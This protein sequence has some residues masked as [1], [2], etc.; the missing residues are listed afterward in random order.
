M[1]L[2]EDELIAAILESAREQNAIKGLL[3]ARA[4]DI[5]EH[6]VQLMLLPT[7]PTQPSEYAPAEEENP[8]QKPLPI[9]MLFT[10]PEGLS[11]T[12]FRQLLWGRAGSGKSVLCQYLAW[13]FAQR[14]YP[15]WNE[16][17][18][19]IIPIKLKRLKLS[20]Y[21]TH[22]DADNVLLTTARILY[23]E[24]L[25]ENQ[26]ARLVN[27]TEDSAARINEGVRL[28]RG[29]LAHKNPRIALLLDG[30]DEVMSD[31]HAP[32]LEGAILRALC[33]HPT[34]IITSRPSDNNHALAQLGDFQRIIEN[35]GFN[36]HDVRVYI[37]TFFD[38]NH[39]RQLDKGEYLIRYLIQHTQILELAQIPLLL[40]LFC[41]LWQQTPNKEDLGQLWLQGYTALYQ[42]VITAFLQY[43]N[44]PD[45]VVN[46]MDN[47]LVQSL[48]NTYTLPL[49]FLAE[50]AYHSFIDLK[51][52]VAIEPPILMDVRGRYHPPLQFARDIQPLG[53]LTPLGEDNNPEALPPYEYIHLTFKEYFTAL[54]IAQN[55]ATLDHA[56]NALST[57]KQHL[58]LHRYHTRWEWVWRFLA[59]LLHTPQG[60]GA[61][62]EEQRERAQ[63]RFWSIIWGKPYEDLGFGHLRLLAIVLEETR[64]NHH[65]AEE[66]EEAWVDALLKPQ[67]STTQP[68]LYLQHMGQ[69]LSRY[70]RLYEK[71]TWRYLGHS[72]QKLPQSLDRKKILLQKCTAFS[73]GAIGVNTML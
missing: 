52:T 42:H 71:L 10:L 47:S 34:V 19:L 29:W 40:H 39:P 25:S 53:L 1:P 20:H 35:K 69:E 7:G 48:Q 58:V 11:S 28:I 65:Y 68:S 12:P 31:L 15:L 24:I 73:G 14:I 67:Y 9:E 46:L 22:H 27:A 43:H 72:P 56:S 38:P 36:I 66:W 3:G 2:T 59:G 32:T 18:D 61:L 64:G 6:F 63:S 23:R 5:R 49:H 17:I 44:A 41:R 33:Q 62:N 4:Q 13:C 21:Q 51:H 57:L 8:A 55:L 37:R 45:A 26:K 54:H 30:L 50:L 70:P 60:L 16:H